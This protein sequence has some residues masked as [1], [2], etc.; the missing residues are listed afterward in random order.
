M[1]E[2]KKDD[3]YI[4]TGVIAQ[5]YKTKLCVNC[6]KEIEQGILCEVCDEED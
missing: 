1:K 4:K 6:G 2:R 3:D 5:N